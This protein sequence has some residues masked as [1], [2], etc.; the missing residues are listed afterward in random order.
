MTVRLDDHIR[1][2]CFHPAGTFVEFPK[3]DTEKSIP[4][5]FEKIARMYPNRIAVKTRTQQV[6]YAALNGAANRL[7]DILVARLG[8]GQRPV[9]LLFPKGIPLIVAILGTLKAGKICVPLDP[10][11]PQ[12]RISHMLA[13]AQA[14]LIVTNGDYLP[15]GESFG[16][17]KQCLNIDEM[18]Y[19][20]EW[21]S[22][23]VRLA[24]MT[25]PISFTL[26][27]RRACRKALA[28]ITATFC[29][30]SWPRPTIIA[31]ARTTG[32]FFLP[33]AEGMFFELC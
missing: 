12:T 4:E 16:Q 20:E 26:R 33:R 21:E 10:T 1:R 17:P 13:N 19:S 32:W 7:A 25:S 24:L 29:F 15:M 23:A 6:T 27:D 5:R 8:R 3:E 18:D 2:K 22:P 28:T 14:T 11:L 9:G 31:F 30:T